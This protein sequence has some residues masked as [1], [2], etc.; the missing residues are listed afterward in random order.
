MQR[1]RGTKEGVEKE[2]ESEEEKAQAGESPWTILK[3]INLWPREDPWNGMQSIRTLMS[4][5]SI[6][7]DLGGN[8]MITRV[9]N[10]DRVRKQQRRCRD[11]LCTA[12]KCGDV[13]V[14]CDN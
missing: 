9:P 1:E 5:L 12:G 13:T 7:R 11:S 14:P 8:A 10:E 2:R 4:W 3:V 6:L